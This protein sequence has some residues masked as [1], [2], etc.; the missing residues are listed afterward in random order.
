MK[1]RNNWRNIAGLV[2]HILIGGLMIFTASEKILGI[3]PPAALAKYG[4]ANQMMLIGSGALFAA[5][6]LLIPHTSS[7]GVLLTSSFWGGA[8]CIHMAHGEP[9]FVQAFLLLLSWAGAYLRSPS[10]LDWFSV[11]AT[12]T[13]EVAA[14]SE[15]TVPQLDSGSGGGGL[16]ASEWFWTI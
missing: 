11:P 12:I 5:V 10:A 13:P 16:L 2:L 9:Y 4:L 1:E 7:L 6:L 14:I 15:Y 3:V 8:I